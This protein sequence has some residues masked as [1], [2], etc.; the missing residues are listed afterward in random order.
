M[1]RVVALTPSL[2]QFPQ[3]Q[4]GS[5]NSLPQTQRVV[6]KLLGQMLSWRGTKYKTL[7]SA[8]QANGKAQFE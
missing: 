5:R 1:G 7:S 2:P 4:G 8:L 6:V 3:W